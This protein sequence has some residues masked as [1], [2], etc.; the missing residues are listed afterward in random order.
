LFQKFFKISDISFKLDLVLSK[1]AHLFRFQS[2]LQLKTSRFSIY[3]WLWINQFLRTSDINFLSINLLWT[4]LKLLFEKLLLLFQL[5]E[6]N[7]DLINLAGQRIG[8][9]VVP[10]SVLFTFYID[11]LYAILDISQSTYSIVIGCFELTLIEF[12]LV[13]E[14]GELNQLHFLFFLQVLLFFFQSKNFLLFRSQIGLE[15]I[16]NFQLFCILYFLNIEREVYRLLALV[17]KDFM[18]LL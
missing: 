17:N 9:L 15:G 8:L 7:F 12:S 11:F 18:I 4:L 16:L 3:F 1:L 10:S 6:L 13:L 5:L 2:Q 14:M